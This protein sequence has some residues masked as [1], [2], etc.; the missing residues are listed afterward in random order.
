MVVPLAPGT[1][2]VGVRLRPGAA[3]AVLG[4]PAAGLLDR[5]T[6]LCDLWGAATAALSMRVTEAPSIEAKLSMAEALLAR[7]LGAADP[8]DRNIAAATRWLARHPAGRMAGLAC[9]LDIG[10]RRLHRR[11]TVAVGYGPKTFQRVLRMQR[12]LALAA[13]DQ[14]PVGGLAGLA[15]EA[16]YADQAHMSRELRLLT[17]RSPTAVLPGAQSTLALSDLFKTDPVPGS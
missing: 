9:L 1:V 3:A 5:D 10:P 17:G 7:R 15:L 8:P 16:G 2:V 4:P 13:R 14:P 6:P 11:F 12:A